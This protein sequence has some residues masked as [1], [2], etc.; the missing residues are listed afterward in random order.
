[1][2]E[3]QSN[4]ETLSQ[5]VRQL[6][7]V[8]FTDMTGYTAMMQEDEQKAKVLGDRQRQTLEKFIPG[9][10]GKILQY[11]GDG[12]L[13]I[14]GSA[15]D[16]V[17]CAIEIQ[18][19]LQTEPKVQLRI[20]LHSGDISHDA[21]GVYGDCVNVASRIE[22]L[23]VPGSVLI[24]DKVYDEIKNQSEIK[25]SLLGKFNLKNVKRQ[26][27]VYAI[28]NNGLV[29][30]TSAQ[31]SVK[32]GSEKSVAVLPFVNMSADT[33]NE[34]FS[35][36]ISEEILNAL[37]HV[38]GLQVTAR[39]SSFS[40]KG[41]NEDIRQI[42][43][44]L[45]VSAVL[46]GSV[47]RAGKKVRITAQLIDTAD[48]Y[49]IWSE[50]YDRDLEDIFEV[51]DEISLKI[52]NRLKE[53]FSVG[54]KKES[55]IKPPTENIEAYNL[56][57]K[58]RYYWNKWNPEDIRKAISTFEEVI[59]LDHGFAIA[60]C[61][62]SYCYSFLGSTGIMPPGE[63][64]PKAKDYTLKAIELDPNNAESHLSLASIKFFHNW[65]FDGAEAS[66]NKALS[67]SLNSSL[68]N[69]VHGWFLIAKG[70]FEK[71][72]EKMEQ[73]VILDPLSLPLMCNLADAYCFAGRWEDGL[74]QYDKVIELDPSFRRGF[75]GKGMIYLAKGDY[76]KAI[77]NLEKYQKL[78]GNP[79]K[80]LSSLGHSYA[81][82]GYIDKAIEC[83][84]KIKQHEQAEPGVILHMDYAFIYAGLKDYD[85]AF[86]YLNKTYDQRM[87]IA[88]LGMIFC[89]RYPM[90][91][92]LHADPRF[93]QLMDKIGLK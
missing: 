74:G 27:E 71:A 55:I 32:A 57:L 60:Y 80:G 53:N 1:M 8:M 21:Q 15:L 43:T 19:E 46:E 84:D 6:A 65:D 93:K 81:A 9:H 79:F 76:E 34:Y 63:A 58:G 68:I 90:L 26:V 66:L 73:A 40:F 13:S 62:L 61:A 85:K 50:V 17:K 37:S 52:V 12:T 92:E 3:I 2:P 29:L 59:H 72:I 10:Q 51:Q 16:A 33:E 56:Y 87:G 42:G 78:I 86:H 82:G 38:E 25:T 67:L 89:I 24:S 11:Y 4:P 75:E 7:A 91:N 23:S 36:G 20:G 41:K 35:D 44:K 45:G 88:C 14:F 31:I 5:R 83:L 54:E 22:S 39:S 70:D 64:F 28:A 30:P 47:R 69:Q 49:H 48:G 18:K 77:E